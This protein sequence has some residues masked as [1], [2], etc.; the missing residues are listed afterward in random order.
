MI[1]Y[2]L[3]FI[4]G[5]ISAAFGSVVG[6]GGGIIIVPALIYLGPALL[7]QPI[8]APL[9][10][11]ISLTVLIV[12]ALSSTLH[13]VKQ[14]RVDFRSGALYIA[15]SGP[16]AM[17]GATVTGQLDPQGFELAFGIFMMLMAILMI[18][19]N[20][21]KPMDVNWSIRRTFT[22]ARG[23]SWDYGYNIPLALTVGFAVGFISGL[24][25]IGGGSLFVPAMVLLF[26]YPPHVA[27]ATSMFVI[28][29]SAF[30]GSAVHIALGEV[31]WAIVLA[32][33]PGAWIGGWFGAWI[34]G[35]MSG[36]A[37]LWV[38]RVALF[39]IAI[40][41]IWAGLM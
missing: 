29:I 28:L 38:L 39:L 27:T 19:R 2:L 17:I 20:H 31:D 22:N 1:S 5:A 10:V 9:A 3:L 41:M 14:K 36:S 4:I 7:D 15:T 18:L 23:E 24:F 35:R 8:S 37:L 16:A 13:F 33:A 32:L 34:T 11:G 40:R 12:T 21:I 6:L 26:R 25:G 30:M